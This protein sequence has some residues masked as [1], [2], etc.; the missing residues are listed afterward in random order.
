MLCLA[1]CGSDPNTPGGIVVPTDNY[2]TTAAATEAAIEATPDPATR[3]QIIDGAFTSTVRKDI[4]NLQGAT[5]AELIHIARGLCYAFANGKTWIEE[6]ALVVHS[7]FSGYDAGQIIGASTAA[8]CPQYN[9]L[10]PGS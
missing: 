7:G 5:D 6:V 3:S 8:Y 10:A 4:P 9:S 1:A 2:G